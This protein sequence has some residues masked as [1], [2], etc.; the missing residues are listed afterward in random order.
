MLY[1]N[2]Q[3]NDV[4]QNINWNSKMIYCENIYTLIIIIVVAAV[5][6]VSMTSVYYK[7]YFY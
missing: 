6:I 5:V 7:K 4:G 3:I 2:S 1:F